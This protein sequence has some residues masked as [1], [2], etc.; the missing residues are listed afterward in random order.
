MK[1]LNSLGIKLFIL[2]AI[3]A[4]FIASQFKS[5]N[6]NEKGNSN[7]SI[8]A[9]PDSQFIIGAFFNAKD[10]GYQYQSAYKFNTWHSYSGPEWGW[11]EN[12]N[13]HYNIDTSYYKDFVTG[14]IDSNNIGHKYANT[15]GQTN[16]RIFDRRTKN[17]L[18][19]RIY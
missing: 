17:R 19:M 12:A 8:S 14:I 4:L 9:A 15:Y 6:A 11:H 1:N 13:D 18:S 5:P 16:N 10:T 7:N 2:T 3:A